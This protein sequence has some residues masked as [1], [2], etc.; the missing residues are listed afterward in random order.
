MYAF[1]SRLSRVIDGDTVVVRATM[2]IDSERL[3]VVRILGVDTPEIRGETREA[4]LAA[5]DFTRDFL[6]DEDGGPRR[7]LLSLT[8]KKDVYGR[9]LGDVSVGG[10]DLGAALI[11]AGHG[12]GRNYAAQLAEAS[13][14]IPS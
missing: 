13:E 10:A 7:A 12:V 2:F 1:Y 3:F 6:V 11:E 4:G 14:A 9:W 8:A 5:A